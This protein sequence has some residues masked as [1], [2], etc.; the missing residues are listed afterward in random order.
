MKDLFFTQALATHKSLVKNSGQ[1][2]TLLL[3]K[4]WAPVAIRRAQS[5]AQAQEAS[6]SQLDHMPAPSIIEIQNPNPA[7]APNPVLEPFQP[8][9]SHQNWLGAAR[10]NPQ[11]CLNRCAY[12]NSIYGEMFC[13]ARQLKGTYQYLDHSH[14]EQRVFQATQNDQAQSPPAN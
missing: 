8:A 10:P 6:T 3:T 5:Q 14:Q 1:R 9:S 2:R 12:C 4:G 11:R 7:P 13:M